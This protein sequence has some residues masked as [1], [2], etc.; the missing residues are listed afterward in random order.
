MDRAEAL[1]KITWDVLGK[2]PGKGFYIKA[3]RMIDDAAWSNPSLL[4]AARAIEKMVRLFVDVKDAKEL[5]KK[6]REFFKDRLY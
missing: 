4:S 3:D 1:K 6:Y 2:R 5:Q